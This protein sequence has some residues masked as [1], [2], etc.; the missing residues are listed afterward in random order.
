MTSIGNNAR[1]RP[2]VVPVQRGP[3][4]YLLLLLLFAWLQSQLLEASL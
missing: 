4:D 3:R 1:V 2:E